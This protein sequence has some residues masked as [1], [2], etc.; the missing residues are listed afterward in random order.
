MKSAPTATLVARLKR[1]AKAAAR[2]SQLTHAEALDA[3]ARREGYADWHE[4][5]QAHLAHLCSVAGQGPGTLPV[6]PKLRKDF[7]NTPNEERSEEEIATWWDRPYAVIMPDG[8]YD[9]R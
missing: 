3:A 2:E 7:D 6:D 5:H 1:E 8:S 4:L 9:V